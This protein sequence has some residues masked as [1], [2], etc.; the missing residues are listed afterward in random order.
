MSRVSWI[1]IG[2]SFGCLCLFVAL[3]AVPAAAQQPT[4]VTL[5]EQKVDA[6]AAQ[7]QDLGDAVYRDPASLRQCQLA[8]AKQLFVACVERCSQTGEVV[9][10]DYELDPGKPEHPPAPRGGDR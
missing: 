7:C 2:A 10:D 4:C 8:C 9:E 6:C 5:C 3:G 1:R